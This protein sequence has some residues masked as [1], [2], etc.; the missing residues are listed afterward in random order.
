MGASNAD[1]VGENL[2]SRR[3][4]GYRSVTAAVLDQQLTVF[5]AVVLPSV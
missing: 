4:S 5:H 3:I 2:D 1:G